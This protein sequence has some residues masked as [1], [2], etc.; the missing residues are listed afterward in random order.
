MYFNYVTLENDQ[1]TFVAGFGATWAFLDGFAS[2]F[3][4]FFFSSLKN[5]D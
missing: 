2:F 3:L 1:A 5:D 4:S